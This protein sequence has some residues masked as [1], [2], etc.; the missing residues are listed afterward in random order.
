MAY[1]CP[2]CGYESDNTGNC[3]TCETPLLKREGE[4]VE[5]D[6]KETDEEELGGLDNEEEFGED[7]G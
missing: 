4:E 7:W 1:I 3:P 5:E 2:D 6:L